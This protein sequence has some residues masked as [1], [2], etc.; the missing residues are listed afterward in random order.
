MSYDGLG[1]WK[2][3]NSYA[4]EIDAVTAAD[5]QR[6]AKE[7]LTKENRTVGIFLRK[8]G[9]AEE[10][11]E[12][13]AL[14]AQA[15][16]MV[17]QSLQRILAETDAAKLREGIARMQEDAGQAPPEMKPAIDL[18]VKRAQERLAALESGKK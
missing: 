8:E 7:Y 9:A 13:A 15:Q 11:P 3:I 1:D 16:A 14:P 10:D 18:I 12:M 17:K 2:Y 5:L 6:V 4:D